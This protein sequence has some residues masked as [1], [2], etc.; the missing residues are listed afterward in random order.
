MRHNDACGWGCYHYWRSDIQKSYRIWKFTYCNLLGFSNHRWKNII[1]QLRKS[2]KVYGIN[3]RLKLCARVPIAFS[4]GP[5]VAHMYRWTLWTIH[6]S[7]V[8]S[9]RI[10]SRVKAKKIRN[11]QQWLFFTVCLN[12]TFADNWQNHDA[13]T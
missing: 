2:L 6:P 3:Q 4:S 9:S 5:P 7:V 13:K 10:N 1:H 12:V 11:I 8:S